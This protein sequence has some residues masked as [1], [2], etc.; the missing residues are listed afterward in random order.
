LVSQK[1]QL[2]TGEAKAGGDKFKV[3]KTCIRRLETKTEKKK[4][5]IKSNKAR[6]YTGQNS[7]PLQPQSLALT[8]VALTV[9]LFTFLP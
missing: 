6:V 2:G 3:S 9:V 4:Q 8:V 7:C 1:K 5:N